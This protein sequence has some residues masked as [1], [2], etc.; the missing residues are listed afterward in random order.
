MRN[1]GLKFICRAVTLEVATT[2]SAFTSGYE[3]GQSVV[4]PVAHHDGN[5]VLTDDMHAELIAE[6]RVAFRYAEDINGSIDR[7]AGVLSKNRRV[8][9][10]MPHPERAAE[11][12]HGM[13]DGAAL[14]SALAAMGVSA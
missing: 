6:D 13:T 14:F 8:L 12:S 2:D 11:E 1:A 9:G 4:Y 3:A 5:Y 10:L 7:I